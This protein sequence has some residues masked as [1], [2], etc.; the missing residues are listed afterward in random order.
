ML[1][2]K[3]GKLVFELLSKTY[4]KLWD[5]EKMRALWDECQD[6]TDEVFVSSIKLHVN[7]IRQT[8][9]NTPRGKYPPCPA[10]VHY[11]ALS[12]EEDI[13]KKQK[14]QIESY[15]QEHAAK[16]IPLPESPHIKGNSFTYKTRDGGQVTIEL[17]RLIKTE[18]G[19]CGD[20]G[21]AKYYTVGGSFEEIY[22]RSEYDDLPEAL[23]SK[24]R[25]ATCIC[26]CDHPRAVHNRDSMDRRI[27]RLPMIEKWAMERKQ[28][29]Q[30][31]IGMER[32]SY[33]EC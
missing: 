15:D 5:Q 12:A 31:M 25:M 33:A 10:D 8:K 22:L 4:G 17:N 20:T 14:Q 3:I 11:H 19:L 2:N 16:I 9:D 26:T 27:P 21:W 6:L 13:R 18:C 30:D 32:I 7:D 29:E 1:S 28:K 23:Q 24:L